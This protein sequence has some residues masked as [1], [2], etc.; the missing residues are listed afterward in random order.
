[1]SGGLMSSVLIRTHMHT[2]FIIEKLHCI[3]GH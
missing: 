3:C 2:V 1:M